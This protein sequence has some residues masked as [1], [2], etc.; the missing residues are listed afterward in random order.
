[1]ELSSREK[2]MLARAGRAAAERV[3][4]WCWSVLSGPASKVLVKPVARRASFLPRRARTPNCRAGDQFSSR[5]TPS[6]SIYF[7]L[8][9][10]V[11]PET[12]YE[13]PLL[14]TISQKMELRRIGEVL[15]RSRPSAFLSRPCETRFG[16]LAATTSPR[17]YSVSA[18]RRQQD[19]AKSP[20]TGSQSNQSSSSSEPGSKQSSQEGAS[21]SIADEIGSLLNNSLE[22]T[23]NSP[24]R[25]TSRFSS[26]N[27]QAEN[28]D[29]T[30]YGFPIGSSADDA[31]ARFRD[32]SSVSG[33]MHRMLSENS[34]ADSARYVSGGRGVG[35]LDFFALSNGPP[36]KSLVEP[37]DPSTLP[38]LGPMV[39]RS[40]AIRDN[41]DLAKGLRQLDITCARNRVRGDF[42]K[43][44]FHERPGLK[45]KRLA[46]ERWR[47]RFMD[48][49][50]ATVQRVQ[51]LKRQ[52]W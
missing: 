50:K 21:S 24:V 6:A 28:R 30:R 43:Q 8:Q 19:P 3:T 40:I 31:S 12:L 7:S 51:Y 11:I 14:I 37:P 47:K 39:G 25:R 2:A 13:T 29:R 18:V 48:G 1:M 9:T 17:A 4:R 16:M 42:N 27:A 38:R 34:A 44:K 35:N 46:S 49:F 20:A 26:P 5:Q 32:S 52:G 41:M 15:L 45:K 10:Y 33:D 22:F 36:Q 23:R